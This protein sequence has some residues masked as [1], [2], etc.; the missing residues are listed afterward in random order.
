MNKILGVFCS[1][2]LGDKTK[3]RW[4]VVA[5]DGC[6]QVTP[7]TNKNNEEKEKDANEQRQTNEVQRVGLLAELTGCG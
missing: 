5:N 3:T 4:I 2:F 1:F 7:V 6:T